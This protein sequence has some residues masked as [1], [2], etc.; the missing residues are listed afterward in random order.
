[1]PCYEPAADLKYPCD[2]LRLPPLATRANVARPVQG[3]LESSNSCPAPHPSVTRQKFSLRIPAPHPV[4]GFHCIRVRNTNPRPPGRLPLATYA[5]VFDFFS[6]TQ[7]APSSQRPQHVGA[8]SPGRGRAF[9][10]SAFHRRT[11]RPS[12][13]LAVNT[14]G[15]QAILWACARSPLWRRRGPGSGS[16]SGGPAARWR[17]LVQGVGLASSEDGR[18]GR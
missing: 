10:P 12:V 18:W 6:E 4:G 13:P 5:S 14:P 1:M 8:T 2:A 17:A 7:R 3:R 15:S 16:A 9:G 11:H